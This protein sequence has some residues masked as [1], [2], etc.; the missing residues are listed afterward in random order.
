MG[1]H[2]CQNLSNHTPYYF[3]FFV[4]CFASQLSAAAL[5]HCLSGADHAIQNKTFQSSQRALLIGKYFVSFII[6]PPLSF[7]LLRHH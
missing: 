7:L 2:I 4:Y 3:I 1:I 5:L 6:L